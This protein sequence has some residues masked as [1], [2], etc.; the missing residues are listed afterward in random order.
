MTA[1]AF[2][3]GFLAAYVS[4]GLLWLIATRT[5][6]LVDILEALDRRATRRENRR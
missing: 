2:A 6:L 3:L 4:I 1:V 5:N